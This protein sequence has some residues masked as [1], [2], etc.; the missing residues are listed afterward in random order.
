MVGI[1]NVL[2][3][4]ESKLRL[5]AHL[6]I[7]LFIVGGKGVEHGHVIYSFRMLDLCI[8]LLLSLLLRRRLFLRRSR[9]LAICRFLVVALF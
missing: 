5:R 4:V 9:R 8:V 7:V 6:F 3:L 1:A 2:V